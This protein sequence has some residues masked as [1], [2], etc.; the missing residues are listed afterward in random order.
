MISIKSKKEK[1]FT[2]IELM[3]ASS[4]F[5]VVMLIVS[6]AILNV[7][8]ANQKSK[9]LRAVMDNLNLTLETMTRTIRFGTNYHC[10]S[11]GVLTNP[12]DCTV[13]P[14][15]NLTLRSESGQ[16]VT[17][18]T[19]TVSTRISRAISPDNNFITSPDVTLTNLKFWVI[20]STT[21]CVLNCA[22]KDIVQ[23]R[24]VIVVSGY[25]GTKPTTRSNFT[26]QTTVS[27][28][29]FDFKP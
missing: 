22:D 23:P 20:G 10:G 25:V 27:Q 13:T 29:V 28:R 8:D 11:S 4:L 21:Y 7:F 24:V 1:G 18:S 12:Q 9:N 15:S 6:G 3:V 2:L 5:L 19:S 14:S 16:T 17:Y 26:L